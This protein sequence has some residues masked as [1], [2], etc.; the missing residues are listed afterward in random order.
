MLDSW[1]FRAGISREVTRYGR[2]PSG[3]RQPGCCPGSTASCRPYA[4]TTFC[5]CLF[6]RWPAIAVHSRSPRKQRAGGFPHGGRW[7][8][9]G[10]RV[11][12]GPLR[13]PARSA[14]AGARIRARCLGGPTMTKALRIMVENMTRILRFAPSQNACRPTTKI[15]V[16]RKGSLSLEPVRHGL[17]KRRRRRTDLPGEVHGRRG[18]TRA[19]SCRRFNLNITPPAVASELLFRRS[20]NRNLPIH[21]VVI[22]VGGRP[23]RDDKIQLGSFNHRRGE[24]NG[25]SGLDR[26]QLAEKLL[27]INEDLHPDPVALRRCPG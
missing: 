3:R 9:C 13:V 14:G 15:D 26:Q 17:A 1:L 7:N 2:P 23:R 24:I 4:P 12:A 20:E 10:R 16:T 5:R 6:P 25:G 22:R 19:G 8:S 18:R 21:K 11:A 27:A